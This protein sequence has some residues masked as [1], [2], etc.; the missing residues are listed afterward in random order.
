MI[1]QAK[2]LQ[3]DEFLV[4]ESNIDNIRRQGYFGADGIQPGYAAKYIGDGFC[5]RKLNEMEEEPER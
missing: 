3:E 2:G 5:V 1:T 4:D